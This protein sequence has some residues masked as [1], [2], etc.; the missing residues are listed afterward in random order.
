M[1]ILDIAILI[2][3]LLFAFFGFRRGLIMSIISLT[4]IILSFIAAKLF[5]IQLSDNIAAKTDIDAKIN[6]YITNKLSA[7]YPQGQVSISPDGSNDSM[8][9]ILSK[10]FHS[11]SIISDTV[12]SLA[13]QITDIVLHILS[14]VIIFIAVLILIKIAGL[15][16]NKLSKL[17]VLSFINKLGGS[18]VGL[19]KGCLLCML[20]ISVVSSL[21]IFTNNT[22]VVDLFNNSALYKYFYI[23]NWLF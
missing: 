21:S 10:L 2:I 17:P 11:D 19:A 9:W 8:Q 7:A 14:F 20:I 12:T 5:Y 1:N 18:V 16:L 13:A 22:S 6:L 3:I 15:I 23:G 4:S